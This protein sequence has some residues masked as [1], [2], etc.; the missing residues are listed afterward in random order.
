MNH[1]KFRA[2]H[3]N[4]KEMYWFDVTWGNFLEG[5]GWIGM[6]P[7]AERERRFRPSNQTQISPKSVELMR[8]TN[9]KD[10]NGNEICEGDFLW[11]TSKK[12]SCSTGLYRIEWN[13]EEC[14]F[15]CE[16]QTPFNYLLPVC[17]KECE[18]VGNKF[19]NPEMHKE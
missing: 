12:Y 9:K 10:K 14:G 6:V 17:W 18:I 19:E 15:T 16:R 1:Y 13:E 8:Y 7:I 2:W 4:Q 5:N 11:Y 3:R